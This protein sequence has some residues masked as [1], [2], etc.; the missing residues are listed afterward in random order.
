MRIISKKNKRQSRDKDLTFVYPELY[1]FSCGFKLQTH[2][3]NNVRKIGV[4][5]N[6][7]THNE[8]GSHWVSMFIDIDHGIIFYFDS[9]GDPIP[10]RIMKFVKRIVAEGESIGTKMVYH[11]NVPRIHQR[12]NSECGMYS[13]YFIITMLTNSSTMDKKITYFKQTRITD[14]FIFALRDKYFN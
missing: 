5:F 12:G 11:S 4:V 8:E 13:L 10:P 9:L 2:I 7:D 6:L 1:R 14:K 3:A